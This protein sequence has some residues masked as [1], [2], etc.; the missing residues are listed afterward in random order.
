M[1]RLCASL[2]L[3]TVTFTI[4][5]DA[6]AFQ[7]VH[8]RA[9]WPH[10]VASYATPTGQHVAAA[11][12]LLATSAGGPSDADPD[13]QRRR[14]LLLSMLTGTIG[15]SAL[16]PSVAEAQQTLLE[17]GAASS[18]LPI[19]QNVIVPPLDDAKY[20]AYEL[21][22]GLRVLLCSDPSTNEAAAAMD[23]HVGACSDPDYVKGLGKK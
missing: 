11:T 4:I 6:L 13:N 21:A 19:F 3:L 12:I 15:T 8:S 9:G 1:W 18:S 14:H 2:I 20:A 10:P 7:S 16:R 22:N 23:V 17:S 5:P